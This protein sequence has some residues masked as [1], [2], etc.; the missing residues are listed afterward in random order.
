LDMILVKKMLK[1]LWQILISM[2][3]VKLTWMNLLDGTCPDLI[4]M[5]HSRNRCL[6]SA[7]MLSESWKRL[8]IKLYSPLPVK[9]L[10]LKIINWSSV[11][12]ILK[13]RLEL[14]LISTFCWEVNKTKRSSLSFQIGYM[15][16][17]HKSGEI[18]F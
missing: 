3:L 9:N 16:H 6:W 14:P 11:L 1:L 18:K 4:H 15:I 10:R 13:I 8:N 17:Q 2:D 12:M 5:A 7:E